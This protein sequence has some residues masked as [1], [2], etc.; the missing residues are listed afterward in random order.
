VK[1]QI[2]IKNTSAWA[3]RIITNYQR[4]QGF[5]SPLTQRAETLKM[6]RLVAAEIS[7]SRA[8][9][10]D[11]TVEPPAIRLKQ[12]R[13]WKLYLKTKKAID[14]DHTTK[15]SLDDY[16]NE[17]KALLDEMQIVL[18]EFNNLIPE[19]YEGEIELPKYTKAQIC[20]HSHYC[21]LR[22]AERIRGI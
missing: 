12:L 16:T 13:S 17:E 14:I 5:N 8:D 10:N 15:D 9:E 19:E 1:T 6:K 2:I 3:V 7:Q 18:T 4:S 20:A 21:Q 22:I 11:S